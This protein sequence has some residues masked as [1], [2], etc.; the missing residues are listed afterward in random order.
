M[1]RG[2]V[3]SPLPR[4]LGKT[5]YLLAQLEDCRLHEHPVAAVE[6]VVALFLEGQVDLAEDPS[7]APVPWYWHPTSSVPSLMWGRGSWVVGRPSPSMADVPQTET[8]HDPM[9]L[10]VSPRSTRGP[11]SNRTLPV[12]SFSP[13]PSPSSDL[14][15]LFRPR[16]DESSYTT[17]QSGQSQFLRGTPDFRLPVLFKNPLSCP[18]PRRFV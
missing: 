13:I 18:F 11:P 5:V 7:V 4:V 12:Y 1:S 6:D 2:P 16:P 9:L 14:R 15:G 3:P 10:L 8:V 17:S